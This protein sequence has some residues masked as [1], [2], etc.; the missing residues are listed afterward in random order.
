[1]AQYNY[2]CLICIRLVWIPWKYNHSILYCFAINQ[3]QLLYGCE[4]FLLHIFIY[5]PHNLHLIFIE[6]HIEKDYGIRVC[7]SYIQ[8]KNL[9]PYRYVVNPPQRISS[10]LIWVFKINSNVKS[11]LKITFMLH[12]ISG[13]SCWMNERFTHVP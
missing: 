7:L 2:T 11:T 12:I 4:G 6:F 8:R 5:F 10:I 3:Q 13:L 1:M 9:T